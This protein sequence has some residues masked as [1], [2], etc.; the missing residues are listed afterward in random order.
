MLRW[1]RWLCGVK[2]H[3]FLRSGSG[4]WLYFDRLGCWPPVLMA[5]R[6]R[7]YLLVHLLSFMVVGFLPGFNLFRGVLVR[8][9]H[10]RSRSHSFS[11]AVSCSLFMLLWL[12]Y[13]RFL[14]LSFSRSPRDSQDA[15]SP[16]SVVS[17]IIPWDGRW[18]LVRCIVC[19]GAA[20]RCGRFRVRE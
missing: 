19:G 2:V 15:V 7:S 3:Q 14:I 13:I 9:D 20:G 6:R 4:R 8:F 10:F 18:S 17:R 16:V 12:G 5:A 11:V 1:F